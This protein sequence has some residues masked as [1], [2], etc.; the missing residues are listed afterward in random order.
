M[1][2]FKPDPTG[3]PRWTGLNSR[4]EHIKEVAEGSLKRLGVEAIDLDYQHCV[5]SEAPN[6]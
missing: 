1:F 2:A 4:P 6:R 5:D 3:G